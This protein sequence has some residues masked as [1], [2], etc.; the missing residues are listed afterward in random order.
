MFYR[1][2]ALMRINSRLTGIVVIN[3]TSTLIKKKL[4][5]LKIIKSYDE[6]ENQ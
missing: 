1:S 2:A 5:D 6:N 3:D 4:Y